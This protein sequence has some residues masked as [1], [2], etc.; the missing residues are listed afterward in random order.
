VR[1][2]RY[3]N[4]ALFVCEQTTLPYHDPLVHDTPLADSAVLLYFDN[5]TEGTFRFGGTTRGAVG[6]EPE[7]IVKP[8]LSYADPARTL[9]VA[10][11][12]V[13]EEPI[14]SLAP[15]VR[16]TPPGTYCTSTWLDLARHH[17][18]W[19]REFDAV[20]LCDTDPRTGLSQAALLFRP[21]DTTG[22]HP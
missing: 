3:A 15:N 4:V 1:A 10:G 12:W 8:Y 18:R 7:V 5:S 13:P 2:G 16:Q 14:A 9:L 11:P 22:G 6:V 17:E 19:A 21:S 20:V